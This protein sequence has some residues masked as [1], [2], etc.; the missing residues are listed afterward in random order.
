M[1]LDTRLLVLVDVGHVLSF[2]IN[3]TF[4]EK[5]CNIF[6]IFLVSRILIYFHLYIY[7]Y[8]FRLIALQNNNFI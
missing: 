4:A 7:I 2:L 5:M 6:A 8:I 3:V 1:H